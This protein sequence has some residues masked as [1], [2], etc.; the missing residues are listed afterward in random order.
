M[1][2]LVMVMV[3]AGE[4]HPIRTSPILTPWQEVAGHIV[5]VTISIAHAA[6]IGCRCLV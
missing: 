2:T 6:A 4:G 1:A 3:I 5:M